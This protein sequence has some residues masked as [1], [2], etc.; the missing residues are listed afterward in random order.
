MP[1]VFSREREFHEACPGGLV[2][3]VDEAGRGPWA[4]PVIAAAAILDPRNI[5]AGIDDSKKLSAPKREYLYAQLLETARIG[6]GQASVE[7]IDA[8][9]ILRA[10]LLAMQRAVAAL[11]AVPALLLIDGRHAPETP[12]TVE[13]LIGG[14]GCS[15]SIAAASIIA[16]VA[17]DRIMADLHTEFPLYG[18]NTNQGYG[19]K[20]HQTAL[21]AH[22]PTPHHRASFMP[23]HKI[24]CG[25][26]SIS[27]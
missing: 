27:P 16:K 15:L 24:L 26:G 9:N 14:D 3:G 8:H 7:E 5:P 20:A 19:T 10:T 23:I 22:G 2:A 25:Q 6:V 13:T 18:W 21:L 1:P 11:P 4:G 12:C 17:R